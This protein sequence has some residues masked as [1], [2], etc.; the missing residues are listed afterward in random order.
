MLVHLCRISRVIVVSCLLLACSD[1]SAKVRLGEALPEA[2]WKAAGEAPAQAEWVVIYG[3]GCGDMGPLWSALK[4]S[5]L[6]MRAV[7]AE[8]DFRRS[9]PPPNGQVWRGAEALAWTRE[10]RV[11]HYPTV[12][13]VKNGRSFDVWDEERTLS[14]ADARSAF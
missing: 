11:S 13:L 2:L 4:H 12:I 14:E 3:A 8:G 7:F 10:A 1:A 6:P 5:K 9:T